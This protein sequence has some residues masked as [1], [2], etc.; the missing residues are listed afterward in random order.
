LSDS[1]LPASG[2]CPTD[3]REPALHLHLLRM[4]S[5]VENVIDV[6]RQDESYILSDRG[7]NLP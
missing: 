2:K 5:G 3:H 4:K 7:S 6:V 1:L